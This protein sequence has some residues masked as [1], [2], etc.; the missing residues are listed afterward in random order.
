MLVLA[1]DGDQNRGP[2]LLAVTWVFTSV[3][4]LVVIAKFYTRVKVLHSTGLDDALVILSMVNQAKAS[5]IYGVFKSR[6]WWC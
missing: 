6:V 3:A 5:M 4:L 1:K 2:E